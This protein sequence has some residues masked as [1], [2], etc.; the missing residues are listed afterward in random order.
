MIGGKSRSV[1]FLSLAAAMGGFLFGYDTAVIN[2]GEQQIQS[3]W[4]LS[5]FVHGLVMSSALWGTVIGAMCGGKGCDRIG[6][7]P[8]LFWVGVLYSVSAIWSAIAFGPS[9][10]MVARFIGGL[11]VGASSIAAPVYIAEISPA[12]CRGKLGGLFQFNIVLGMV[13]SQFVNWALG[14]IGENAW[15]WMLG[16]E[17]VP[18]L[19][20]TLMT[21]WLSESPR[22]LAMRGHEVGDN[23]WSW[24]KDGSVPFSNSNSELQLNPSTSDSN[25]FSRG[26]MRPILLAF[27]LAM[28]NQLSGI[29]AMMYFAKRVFEMA[30]LSPQAALGTAAA[31]SVVLGLGTFVGLFLIDRLGRRTLLIVGSIGCFAA[32]FATAAAFV[33]DL[34]LLA[35]LCIFP[36]IVFFALG[37]GVVIWGCFSEIFPQRFRAEGQSFGSFTHWTFCALLTFVFPAMA[38]TWAPAAIFA[39]FG[40]CLVAHLFWA[41]FICP[42]TKGKALEDI[43]L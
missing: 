31:M 29:N 30:G 20:F 25:F 40:T 7:K 14:G 15:R 24:R 8:T 26:N 13:V 1:L 12:E 22:Y 2:G 23:S 9:D 37:Q 33:F 4:N 34:G 10:L 6:R 35:A 5:S 32:H 11:G 36:F 16:A 21:L 18:A 19:V 27:F 42:E 38:A 3:V 28:F 17:A 41:I 39:F 43:N